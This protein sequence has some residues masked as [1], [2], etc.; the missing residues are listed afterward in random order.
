M[1]E[2]EAEMSKL[3]WAEMV[4]AAPEHGEAYLARRNASG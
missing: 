1:L 3:A 4:G 2:G